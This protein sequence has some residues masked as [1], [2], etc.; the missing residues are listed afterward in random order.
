MVL[1]VLSKN[2]HTKRYRFITELTDPRVAL[3]SK[4]LLGKQSPRRISPFTGSGFTPI[5]PRSR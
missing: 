1:Q 5:T 2:D 4:F 3:V